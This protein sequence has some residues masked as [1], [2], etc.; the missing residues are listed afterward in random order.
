VARAWFTPST[1]RVV[2]RL[3]LDLQ[4]E[5]TVDGLDAAVGPERLEAWLVD[6]RGHPTGPRP[7]VTWP[8]P[9]PHAEERRDLERLMRASTS[10][11]RRSWLSGGAGWMRG[12]L[13]AHRELG[14]TPNPGPTLRGPAGATVEVEFVEPRARLEFEHV[15]RL[16]GRTLDWEHWTILRQW[17]GAPWHCRSLGWSDELTPPQPTAPVAL[18]AQADRSD[19]WRPPPTAA[20]SSALGTAREVSLAPG[21]PLF[22]LHHR[23]SCGGALRTEW[24]VDVGHRPVEV[25]RPERSLGGGP[26]PVKVIREGVLLGV[27]QRRPDGALP[28]GWEHRVQVEHRVS[29]GR[30]GTETTVV[31]ATNDSDQV[32]SFV[33]S[34]EAPVREPQ[35]ILALE[36]RAELTHDG[37]AQ[38]PITV[39]A[40]GRVRSEFRV[41]PRS[42]STRGMLP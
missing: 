24:A 5:A 25:F 30:D 16:Q 15:A 37:W 31:E 2:R 41:R 26:V 7:Q 13:D 28:V 4:G 3:Q 8:D 33:W 35:R 40:H 29:L 36:P 39:P 23:Q 21:Q 9:D 1:V 22:L 32:V 6:D 11:L 42:G 20:H 27:T 38:I 18:A 10:R 12:M 19:R 34:I 14:P 17:T